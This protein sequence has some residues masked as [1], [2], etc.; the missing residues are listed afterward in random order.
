MCRVVY[1]VTFQFL[2][3][4]NLSMLYDDWSKE[5]PPYAV[6]KL[7]PKVLSS[8]S[9]KRAQL[10]TYIGETGQKLCTRTAEHC[11]HILNEAHRKL[12]VSHHVFECAG[13]LPVPFRI[14]PIYKMP[15]N[16]TRVERESKEIFFQKKFCPSLH[17]GPRI[18]N[19]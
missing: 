13:H 15:L 4:M 16:C 17:P 2:L 1:D 6:K 10:K 14:M 5:S 18:Q 9:E 8:D 19:D 11:C 12:E 7:L 3:N